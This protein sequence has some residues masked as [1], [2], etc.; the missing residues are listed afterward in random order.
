[1][2]DDHSIDPSGNYS[3]DQEGTT[4]T[5]EEPV[6]T[7][8]KEIAIEILERE[9]TQ[10][11]E[12]AVSSLADEISEKDACPYEIK[13]WKLDIEVEPKR[14]SIKLKSFAFRQL[15]FLNKLVGKAKDFFSFIKNLLI[16]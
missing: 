9:L 15:D 7:P 6:Q 5:E 3:P 10:D 4:S 13:I 14:L 1:M 12:E 11:M 2:K 16:K 8:L